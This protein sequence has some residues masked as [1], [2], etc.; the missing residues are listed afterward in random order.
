MWFRLEAEKKSCKAFL[1]PNAYCT[2]MPRGSCLGL[3]RL[4]PHT[5]PQ[6]VLA[7]PCEADDQAGGARDAPGG[8][9]V[10]GHEP[11]CDQGEEAR[12]PPQGHG[13]ELELGAPTGHQALAGSYGDH[14]EAESCWCHS[15]WASCQVGG[16]RCVGGAGTPGAAANLPVPGAV[17]GGT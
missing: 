11:L 13:T 6:P 5:A 1:Y 14:L 12:G 2:E 10:G 3:G 7:Q 15:R 9:K 8:W 17:T 4:R 16:G